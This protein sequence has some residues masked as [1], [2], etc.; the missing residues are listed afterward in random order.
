MKVNTTLGEASGGRNETDIFLFETRAIIPVIDSSE[1]YCH[2][3]HEM[4]AV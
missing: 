3:V 1:G 4:E 2:K